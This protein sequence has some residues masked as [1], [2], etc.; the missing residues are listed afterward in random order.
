MCEEETRRSR[1][2]S[3]DGEKRHGSRRTALRPTQED[4][5]VNEASSTRF[6]CNVLAVH[7][8]TDHLHLHFLYS[9]EADFGPAQQRENGL[10][11]FH[12]NAA[13]T[14]CLLHDYRPQVGDRNH[15]AESQARVVGCRAL[16]LLGAN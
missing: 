5:S 12:E 14:R 2:R 1:L 3:M 13:A 11:R 6:A 4:V 9:F 15:F 7:A 8:D 10:W 16:N